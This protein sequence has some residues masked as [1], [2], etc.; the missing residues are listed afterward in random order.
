MLTTFN[1]KFDISVIPS[2]IR[3]MASIRPICMCRCPPLVGKRCKKKKEEK[4]RYKEK[5]E[6]KTGKAGRGVGEGTEGKRRGRGGLKE[7]ERK[8]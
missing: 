6:R 2:D 1:P 7:K 3:S 4:R 8:R 5:G